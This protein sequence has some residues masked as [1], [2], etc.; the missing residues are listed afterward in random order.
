MQICALV[1]WNPTFQPLILFALLSTAVAAVSGRLYHRE[2]RV[3]MLY[4]LWQPRY[5]SS[6][7][8]SLCGLL[9]RFC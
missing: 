6:R 5:N 7:T 4:T 2:R 9:L 8:E 1:C 3:L